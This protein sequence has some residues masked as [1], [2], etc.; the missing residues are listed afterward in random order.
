MK[1]NVKSIPDE[2]TVRRNGPRTIIA[3]PEYIDLLS[4]ADLPCLPEAATGRGSVKRLCTPSGNLLLRR[5]R[6][7]GLLAGFNKDSYLTP[8]RAIREINVSRQAAAR[9]V[10]V[11]LVAGAI[12]DSKPP[13]RQLLLATQEIADAIDLHQY[14]VR[15]ARGT[16]A[17]A[18][19]AVVEATARA[20]RKMHDAG[21]FHA[22]LQLKNILVRHTSENIEVF[23]IDLDKSAIRNSLPERLRAA[24]LRRL[25]RSAVKIQ[26]AHALPEGSIIDDTVRRLFLRT[27]SGTGAI[28]GSDIDTFIRSCRRNAAIHAIGWR[29]FANNKATGKS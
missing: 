23:F 2:Y 26:Q 5:Y 7:G 17:N 21:L 27:Y 22:D 8:S 15:L 4:N 19:P 9:K 24:N 28:F 3:L 25:N 1:S 12:I 14:A 16:D 11:P 6:R 13:F 20:V 10:P 18:Q 29:I